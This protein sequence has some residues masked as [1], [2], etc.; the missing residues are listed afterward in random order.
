[1]ARLAVIYIIDGMYLLGCMLTAI[2]LYIGGLSLLAVMSHTVLF[3][4]ING[5]VLTAPGDAPLLLQATVTEFLYQLSNK[6]QSFLFI[7]VIEKI[8]EWP[9]RIFI[10]GYHVLFTNWT[11]KGTYTAI[12]SVKDYT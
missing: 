8:A 12:A 3:D 7:Q 2:L 9:Q 1:M 5:Q 10:L 4:M 6:P 11:F